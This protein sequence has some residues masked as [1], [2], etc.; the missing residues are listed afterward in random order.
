MNYNIKSPKTKSEWDEYFNFRWEMLRKPLGMPKESLK[1]DLEDQS[2]H[3]IALNKDQK[4]V[5]S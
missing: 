2:H 4:I 5:G 3:L 1:D